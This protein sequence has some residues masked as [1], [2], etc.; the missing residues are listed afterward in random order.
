MNIVFFGPQGSGKG[1]QARLLCERY[2]FFYF[3]SGSYL[4]KIAESNEAVKNAQ[5]SGDLNEVLNREICTYLTAF[6]DEK[7][8]YDD[9]VFDGFP[10]TVDQYLFLKKWLDQKQVGLDLAIVLEIS[11]KETLRRLGGRRQDPITGQIYN[12]VTEGLPSGIDLNTLKQRADDMP[13]AI[14]KRLNLYH[15]LTEPLIEEIGK[16]TNVVKVNGERQVDEIQKDLVQIVEKYK[17]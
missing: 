2:G 16:S 6:F 12:L 3:E 9:I 1:T 4:R 11:E 13:E 8:M 7:N 14:K 15:S 5:N 10:R 17:K